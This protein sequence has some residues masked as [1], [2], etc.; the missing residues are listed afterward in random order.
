MSWAAADR[1]AVDAIC[2]RQADAGRP[3][4]VGLAGA[5]GSGKTTMAHR[6]AALL[7]AR[8]LRT[9]VLALDD[10]YLTRDQ[11][12]ALARDVHPL[13]ATRGVPGTHDLALLGAVLDAL[14]GTRSVSV[15]RF[16]KARDDRSA[17]TLLEP[18]FDTVL[19]EG[20]CIG[21]LPQTDDDLARPVNALEAREDAQGIWRSWVNR[22]LA[23]DYAALFAR[24]DLR[25]LLRAP[26]FEVVHG[27]RM[28]QERD[29]PLPAKDPAQMARFVAH[30]ERITRAMLADCPAD[31][32][33]ALDG[34]REPLV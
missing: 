21:A 19:L 1:A 26:G 13:L 2:A 3:A 16:D 6:L 10:F 17:P 33:I 25:I 29:L 5:Q 31:L 8:G 11:R 27:W 7:E 24:L 4:F 30:F 15:P 34:K 12:H 23:S 32:V 14:T 28:Q 18:P 9:A 22:R 20:W